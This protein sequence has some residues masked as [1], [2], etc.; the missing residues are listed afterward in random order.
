M[1]GGAVPWHV[2]EGDVAEGERKPGP[3][4]SKTE[5]GP[6]VVVVVIVV[7]S[8]RAVPWAEDPGRLLRR[9]AGVGGALGA[10]WVG[11]ARTTARQ[12]STKCHLHRMTVNAA[13]RRR[14]HGKPG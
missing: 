8:C 6:V 12:R 11:K 3:Q 1:R 4:G 2:E 5:E 10:C 9:A 14:G 13:Y 7:A